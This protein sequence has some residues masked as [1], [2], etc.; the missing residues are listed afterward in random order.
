MMASFSFDK[1]ISLGQIAN[2]VVFIVVA[3]VMVLV[4]KNDIETTKIQVHRNTTMYEEVIP[5]TYMRKDV[6]EQHQQAII[7]TLERI[8][9]ELRRQNREDGK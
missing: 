5:D 1:N 2:M 4:L 7:R 6:F 8:E 9:G 3:A